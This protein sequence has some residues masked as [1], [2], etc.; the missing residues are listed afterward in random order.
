M[1][2]LVAGCGSGKPAATPPSAAAPQGRPQ[3]GAWG[4]DTAGMD[5]SVA[6]GADFYRYASGRWLATTQIPADKP[7]YAMFLQLAD[8]SEERTRQILEA[9]SGAPGSD[10]QR[11][12]DYYRAFMD[13]AAI[14]A[15]GIAPIQRELDAIA[16]IKD[17]AGVVLAFAAASRQMSK[18][19][20][21]TAV[22]QDDR[23]PETH[24]AIL[25]QSGLG[26]PDRDMYDGGAA[27]FAA[28]R[29]GYRTYIAAMFALVGVAPADAER[30]AAAVYA[31]EEK[32]AQTHWTRVQNRDPQRTYNKLTIAELATLASG[33]DWK[34]WLAAVGLAGQAR[35]NVLQPPAIA[36]ISQ[37]V[38]TEPLAVWKDY[39]VLRLVSDAAP[40]L[41]KRFVDTQFEMFG[42]T[43]SGAE[44][45]QARW[46]R[47]VSDT[48]DA[49][50][51]AIGQIYVA[52][53]FTPETKA[54]ADALV[55][56]LLAAMSQRLDGLAWMS[57][58]TK[59]RAKA[60]LAT[61]RT[62]IG[63]PERWRDYSALTI[64]PGDPVGNAERAAE[65]E[66]NRQL[67]RLGK[68]VDRD[69]WS[70]PPMTVDAYYSATRNEI[71]FPAAILQPPFFDPSADDA[72]NYGGI[73][74]VIGHEIS[75]GFDD[76][77]SQYDAAGKLENWWTKDDADKFKAATAKLVAQYSAYCPIPASGGKPAQCV[78]GELT[79]GENIAD[80]AGV[81]IA[82][83]AYK[84]SL[85]G[86]TP[87]VLDGFTGDQRFFLGFAQI[88][89][90]L[91]RDQNLSTRLVVDPHSPVM[92]RAIT[93]RNLDAWYDAFKPR[94]GDALYLP[95][96]Q[97]VRIW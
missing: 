15:A 56:N 49:L 6:P 97:R 71:V 64:Q 76:E 55:R 5:R 94:P 80:L 70:V 21:Y 36:A 86:K 81:T 91:Y 78:K 11:I 38:K 90:G 73:G 39:L 20:F 72:V 68:P 17:R 83:N 1:F 24:I 45:L 26:L 27:Q 69:E 30:R 85:G 52:R 31:L 48:T 25:A 95:P 67:A 28:V 50:G 40:Y 3:I 82:Y 59:A 2:V 16:R 37:L 22:T 7:L 65:F 77:G 12:G 88:W 53:Y 51:E 9:A 57:A 75:H 4:F 62:K 34:P 54:R 47:G 89:R 46:K 60:K 96:D 43:L 92:L 14:E 93:V 63:Y 19:P 42:K 74:T 79:L 84:L 44:Q 87:P 32:I 33:I 41:P 10:A 61:Y 66:Y 8:L 13:E 29:D 23:D 58:E 35:I 18:N